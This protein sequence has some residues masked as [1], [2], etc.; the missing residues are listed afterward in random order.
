MSGNVG[1][2]EP[3]IAVVR[4]R[5]RVD[6]RPE[7]RRTMEMLHVKRKFWAT[8]VPAT[9]SYMGMLRVVKDYTTYGEIDKD[10]LVEL[11]RR[12]GELRS[13]GRVTEEWLRENTEFDGVDDLVEALISGKARLHKLEWLKPYFRLHP[14]SGGFKRTTKRGYRDGG[15]LGYRGRDINALLRRMM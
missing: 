3:L 8:I 10:T 5:G 11:L 1:D 15:E 4:I 14:P 7:I 13:G 6:V 12:R 9:E 2:V